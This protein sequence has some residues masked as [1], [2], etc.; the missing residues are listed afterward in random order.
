MMRF[1]KVYRFTADLR[2][3]GRVFCT[4]ED[5]QDAIEQAITDG[6]FDWAIAGV[7]WEETDERME[8]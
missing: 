1:E 3:K 8:W 4:A 7:D 5:F 6:E 2:I